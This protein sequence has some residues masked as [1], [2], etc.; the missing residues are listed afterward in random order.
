M[1]VKLVVVGEVDEDKKVDAEVLAGGL[2]IFVGTTTESSR[3]AEEELILF[4][5]TL[6]RMAFLSN[7]Q[8]P[9]QTLLVIREKIQ[10]YSYSPA[11][12]KDETIR[13]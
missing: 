3:I 9:M 1:R 6:S 10:K 8:I 4:R 7:G 5:D 2:R 13:V 11:R 12:A